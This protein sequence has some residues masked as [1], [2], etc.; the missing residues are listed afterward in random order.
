LQRRRRSGLTDYQARRR[1]ISSQ[2]TLLVVRI[3]DKNVTAQFLRPKVEGD[4]VVASAHS[5]ELAKLGWKGSPKSTPACY[6]L[7][8]LAGKKAVS[9]GIND[10]VLYMGVAP[11]V[12]GSRTAAFVKG[13]IDAGVKIPFGEEAIP[14]D[15]RLTGK[16]I[17][18]Y[19]AKLAGED[20]EL[21]E[22]RFS[23]LLKSGFVPEDYPANVEKVKAAISKGVKQ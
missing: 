6:M 5:K 11:F 14:G 23:A 19:A 8:L 9:K 2:G 12:R 1:A 10:A 13:A 20:K 4:E 7:G 17:A 22:K 21:Y 15:D 18:D 16:S 3:S